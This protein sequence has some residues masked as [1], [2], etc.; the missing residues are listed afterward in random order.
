MHW[1]FCA[2]RLSLKVCLHLIDIFMRKLI[3]CKQCQQSFTW[4]NWYWRT[5]YFTILGDRSGSESKGT[6]LIILTAWGIV[7]ALGP[8]SDYRREPDWVQK[9]QVGPHCQGLMIVEYGTLVGWWLAGENQNA[10]KWT[11]YSVTLFTINLTQTI[12]LM[13]LG[14]HSEKTVTN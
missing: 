13:D 6:S 3:L 7:W 14:F 9:S 12:L 8:Q 11:Y 1:L 10:W 4:Q 2:L 5:V